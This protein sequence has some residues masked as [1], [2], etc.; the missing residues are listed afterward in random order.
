MHRGPHSAYTENLTKT[1][2][3]YNR[4]EMLMRQ[5]MP[6]SYFGPVTGRPCSFDVAA[7]GMALFSL[8]LVILIKKL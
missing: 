4:H 6:A 3:V 8:T 2:I 5:R 1:F 7:V